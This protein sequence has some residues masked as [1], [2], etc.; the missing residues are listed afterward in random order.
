[1]NNKQG[2]NPAQFH[3]QGQLTSFLKH[4]LYLTSLTPIFFKNF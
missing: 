4:K 1:M 3:P 2:E